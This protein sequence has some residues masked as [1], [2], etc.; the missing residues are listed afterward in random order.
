MD[1]LARFANVF[2]QAYVRFLD[3]QKQRYKPVKPNR[4]FPRAHPILYVSHASHGSAV[5]VI[6]IIYE[7]LSKVDPELNRCFFMIL[8][9]KVGCYLVDGQR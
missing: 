1:L 2:D 7:E 3:L 4:S 8:I 9:P 5:P 6:G